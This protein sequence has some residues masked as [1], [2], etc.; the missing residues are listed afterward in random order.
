MAK[1]ETARKMTVAGR[2]LSLPVLSLAFLHLAHEKLNSPLV[3]LHSEKS[4]GLRARLC[5]GSRIRTNKRVLLG[6]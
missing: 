3:S 4:C 5:V 6:Q 1:Q 2:C